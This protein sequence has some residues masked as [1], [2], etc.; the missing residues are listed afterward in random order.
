MSTIELNNQEI[1]PNEISQI[2]SV[3]KN[4]N[5][6]WQY[7]V[8]LSGVVIKSPEYRTETLA[9]AARDDFI[10]TVNNNLGNGG[11]IQ[12]G[13]TANVT[14]V[15]GKTGD[16][17]L[18]QDN[19]TDG[20]T[21]KQY[22][23]TEK[24]K[25]A[26]VEENAEENNISDANATDLTDGGDSTLHYHASDRARSNH[27]GTQTAST[28][29]DFDTEVSNNTDVVKALKSNR[30]SVN[31]TG[32]GFSVGDAIYWDGTEYA[33]AQADDADTLAFAIVISV[34]DVN[35]FT[36]GANGFFTVTGHGFTEDEYLYLSP[37]TAGLLTPTVPI[38]I[39]E[40]SNPLIYVVDANTLLVLPYRPTVA[41]NRYLYDIK[42]V[43]ID[44]V[45]T[46][47]DEIINVDDT[48]GDVTITLPEPESKY[49]GL[50]FDIKKIKN[51]GNNV[52]IEV[53]GTG[54]TIDES[55]SL[56]ITTQYT[57]YTIICDGSEYW[58][59]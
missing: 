48:S 44:Y 16:V 5:N 46:E 34:E 40:Y 2:N 43:S 26:T 24:N 8:F 54:N 7:I 57:S 18:N 19:I 49:E 10:I 36:L 33:L 32:H 55:A 53:D 4:S 31:Q 39:G 50:R 51:S 58:T 15:N 22:S 1:N 23:L 17:N 20:I 28:I 27:T 6:K 45:A 35:N 12:T 25:L 42:S 14:S 29:S 9:D 30:L 38:A 56:S 13:E 47:Y 11:D 37:D 52:I 59:Y 21:Y 41:N 3:Y